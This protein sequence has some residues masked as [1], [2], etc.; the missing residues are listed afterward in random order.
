MRQMQAHSD[1]TPSALQ[2]VRVLD[3]SRL[4]AGNILTHAL[5]DFGAEVIKIE[6]PNGDALR[7]WHVDGQSTFWQVY[8]RNKKSFAINLRKAGGIDLILKLVATSH[9]FVENFRPGTLE[10]MGL[11]PEVLLETNPKLV[12]VRIS[13][14]GQG[15]PY[16]TRPGFGTMI[17]AMSGFASMNGFPD[18]E[19]VLPPVPLAD[20]VAGLYGSFSVMVALRHAEVSGGRGQVI[21]LPLFDP[22]FAILGPQ[23]A[24][25]EVTG[26]PRPRAGSRATDGPTPRNTYQT[27][28]GK[29]I[30]LSASMQGTAERLFHAIGM[31]ELMHDPRFA[32]NPARAENIEPL[33]EILG[34]YFLGYDRDELLDRLSSQDVTVAPVMDISDILADPHVIERQIVTRMPDGMLGHCVVPRLSG[35]PGK[36]STSAPSIGEHNLEVLASIGVA[37]D[38]VAS[39]IDEEVLPPRD[40]CP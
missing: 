40:P 4:V 15:G 8:C 39:L 1:Q 31:P 26:K 12:I 28:D 23:A 25:F 11:S 21:D 22:L 37:A 38:E 6:T 19:P 7:D 29:W 34:N 2:G 5:A 20:T 13:G 35:T 30:A 18:R 24:D 36:I 16:A 9:I 3:L 33:D 17:E 32:T 10:K 27:R 14:F